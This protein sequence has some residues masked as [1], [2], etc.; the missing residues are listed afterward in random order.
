MSKLPNDEGNPQGSVISNRCAE[1]WVWARCVGEIGFPGEG[2]EAINR[3]F[4]RVWAGSG[5]LEG[6]AGRKRD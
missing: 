1:A 2:Y 4:L 5:G 6:H 3:A